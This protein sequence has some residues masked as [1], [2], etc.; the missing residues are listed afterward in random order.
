MTVVNSGRE[1]ATGTRVRTIGLCL[2]ILAAGGFAW[3]RFTSAAGDTRVRAKTRTAADYIVPWNC[4]SCGH[5]EQQAAAPGVRK[6]PGCAD[7]TLV[8]TFPWRCPT[9]G[10]VEIRYEYDESNEPLRIR[11][12]GAE[13]TSYAD[14]TAADGGVF[15]PTCPKCG[16]DLTP[17]M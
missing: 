2:L 3:Y 9:H 7:G 12:G 11:I 1:P 17:P 13:W 4:E 10:V 6:C 5:T 14:A 16:K 15:L 8:V